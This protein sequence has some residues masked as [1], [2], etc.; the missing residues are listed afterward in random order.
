MKYEIKDK[1][2][3]GGNIYYT[4][5]QKYWINLSNV[6]L[7]LVIFVCLSIITFNF[8]LS[9]AT[10]IGYSMQPTY[11]QDYDGSKLKCDTAYYSKFLKINRQDVVVVDLSK[12]NNDDY[13]K[14]GIKR[15]IAFGGDTVEFRQNKLYVNGV[16]KQESYLPDITLNRNMIVKIINGVQSKKGTW[17]K[18][19]YDI[20]NFNLDYVK[21]VVD[22]DSIF[23]LGDNRVQSYDCS[24]YG[25]QPKEN[26]LAKIVFV[27]PY[28]INLLQYLWQQ[29]CKLF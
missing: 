7:C 10:I 18:Y 11:N 5:K 1:S 21:F 27:K 22:E 17:S 20:E 2:K 3:S 23:Y 13:E 8:Y 24:S 6:F 16:E 14:Y 9:P 29:F 25:P 12:V 19:E 26:L 28:N 15:V 4:K